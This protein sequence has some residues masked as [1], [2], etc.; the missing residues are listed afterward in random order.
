MDDEELARLLES[1]FV[2]EA[3]EQLQR[4]GD[5]L[6]RLESGAEEAD[7]ADALQD[8]FRDAHNLKGAAR[9]VSADGIERN[10]HELETFFAALRD[11]P[12]S[13]ARESFDAA[14]ALLRDSEQG[15]REL[16]GEVAAE[17]QEPAEALA[18]APPGPGQPEAPEPREP[19]APR[20]GVEETIRVATLKLD[21]LMAQVGELVAARSRA[22]LHVAEADDVLAQMTRLAVGRPELGPIHQSLRS[23]RD[24]FA[25]DSRR[26][27]QLT[28]DLRDGV[29]RTRMLPVATILDALP[30][31][32]R[33]LAGELGK[34][35][36]VVLRGAETEVDRS[37]LDQLRAP[38]TH[39]LRNCLDHGLEPP[40][41]REREGKPRR[42]TITLEARHR[43]P[44]LVLTIAD[45]GQG[46]DAPR[47]RSVAVG[48]GLI[49]KA[50][51][52]AMDER[53]AWQLIFRSGFS[54]REE[55][56]DVSGRG[57]GMDVVREHVERLQGAVEVESEPGAGT[58]FTIRVPLSI[59]S[60]RCLLVL[61]GSQVYGLPLTGVDRLVRLAADDVHLVQGRSA[62]LVDG[63][64]V[65]L[66]G[67]TA[68]LDVAAAGAPPAA[69]VVLGSRS[70]R[71][72]LAIDAPAGSED[73]V[74][75]P[76]GPPLDR[77]P[78]WRARRSAPQEPSSSC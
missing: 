66:S 23:L 76:L 71:C 53:D 18:D 21:A 36:A 65:P 26:I 17:P 31:A 48:N 13:T 6:M 16:G 73:L 43:G 39:L 54:T 67:L 1:T 74:V 50:A 49:S 56:S 46:L 7:A 78:T 33:D 58:R 2:D 61:A 62:I 28:S 68:I 59:A 29:N 52:A 15:V 20:A 12:E 24:G 22:E 19:R 37:V 5:H 4:I 77:S 41:A 42:G 45:D 47:L 40:E 27:A 55:L 8:A 11:S 63:A 44:E 69:A 14:H 64:P 72:A 3:R 51:A 35:V 38:L 70:R 75:K 34:D 32:A 30:R 9:A 57:I 25:T 10:A 60:T